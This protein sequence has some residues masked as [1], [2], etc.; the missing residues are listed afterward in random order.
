MRRTYIP[1]NR[2]YHFN[3]RLAQ[4]NAVDPRV[5]RHILHE[6]GTHYG[7]QGIDTALLDSHDICRELRK[8]G[9]KKYCERWVQIKYRL[10]TEDLSELE[11]YEEEALLRIKPGDRQ[12]TDFPYFWRHQWLDDEAVF[13]F[14]FYF[15][16]VSE[17]FDK[18]FFKA[19]KRY[20]S[21]CYAFNN[22]TAK[23]AR[24][25]LVSSERASHSGQSE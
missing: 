15:A 22:P 10:T 9:Y 23:H 3:E 20:T 25:N 2:Q 18:M 16:K 17:T 6:L 11:D 14:R 5:P 8:R 1:Y 24:H 21:K 19:G 7:R 13:A 12:C 4:R